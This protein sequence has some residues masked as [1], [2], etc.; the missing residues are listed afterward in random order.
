MD[1]KTAFEKQF[2]GLGREELLNF[3]DTLGVAYVPQN[4]DKSLRKK[5]LEIMGDYRELL[6]TDEGVAPAGDAEVPEQL[7][8]DTLA[9]LNLRAQG[10]WQGRRRNIELHRAFDYESQAPQFF[11]WGNLHVYVPFGGVNPLPYPIY[12]ILSD[13]AKGERLVRRRN[14]DHDGRIFYREEWVPAQRFMFTDHGDDPTTAHLP[15]DLQHQTRMMWDMSGGFKDYSLL[16]FRDLCRRLRIPATDE[17]KGAEMK[18]RIKAVIG[19]TH[20]GLY[21]RPGQRTPEKTAAA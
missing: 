16:Q 10:Q 13:T 2:V 19:L 18:A 5:L 11:G 12:N 21:A 3:C 6:I 15:T 20:E 7:D 1:L 17:W 8:I 9:Q 14:V 4:N